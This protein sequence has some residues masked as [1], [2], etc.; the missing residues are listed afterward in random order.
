MHG[1]LRNFFGNFT[2]FDAPGA[3]NGAGQGTLSL[4]IN[5]EGTVAGYDYD[6]SGVAH[7]F[8]RSREGSFVTYEAAGAGTGP[9]Q[10]TGTASG[11]GL[12]PEGAVTGAYINSNNT[13]HGYVRD[14]DGTITSIDPPGAGNGPGQGTDT[15][16]LN[17]AGIIS[18]V[19]VDSNNV[20]HG[21]VR[22]LDERLPSSTFP[23][24][25]PP[26][27]KARFHRG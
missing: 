24:R 11:I 25:A 13:L 7:A 1:Y 27:A 8:L 10:G 20:L 23:E 9:G 26:L 2:T 5:P 14:P 22:D 6:S 21:F 19:Y 12:N 3:G 17:F 15:D 4:N 18:G 16:G